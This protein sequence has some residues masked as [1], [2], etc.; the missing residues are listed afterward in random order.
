MPRVYK[1][2]YIMFCIIVIDSRDEHPVYFH[3]NVDE[4]ICER[5]V[6][7]CVQPGE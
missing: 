5:N 7:R 2:Y 1:G 6:L 3:L 4:C